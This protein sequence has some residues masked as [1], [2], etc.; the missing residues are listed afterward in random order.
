LKSNGEFGAFIVELA[1]ALRRP[2]GYQTS[3]T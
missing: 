2:G 1:V 3:G